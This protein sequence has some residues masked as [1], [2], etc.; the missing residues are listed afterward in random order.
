MTKSR[1]SIFGNVPKLDLTDFGPKEKA[2]ME[3]PGAEAVRTVTQTA[4]FRSREA[5]PPEVAPTSAKRAARQFRTGRN[6]QFNAKASQE[7]VDAIYA[8]TGAQGWVLGY[9]LE[10]AI[11]ALQRE[12]DSAT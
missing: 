2:G 12:L 9:T 3:A 7:T 8:V 1:A 5:A 4:N 10:R 11:A 6:V